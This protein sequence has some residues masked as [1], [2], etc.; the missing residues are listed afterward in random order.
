MV[1]VRAKYGSTRDVELCSFFKIFPVKLRKFK[2]IH[3]C[4]NSTLEPEIQ[5][6]ISCEWSHQGQTMARPVCSAGE[7]IEI[8]DATY[9]R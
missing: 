8:V 1:L 3:L 2:I 4:I 6:V 9:G 7:L 5:S